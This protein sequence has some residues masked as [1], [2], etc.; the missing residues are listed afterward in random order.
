MSSYNV[1]QQHKGFKQGHYDDQE[2]SPDCF[3]SESA[4]V[5]KEEATAFLI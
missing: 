5:S 2:N 1:F 4:V 3:Q